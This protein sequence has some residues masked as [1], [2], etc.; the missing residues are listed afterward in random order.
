MRAHRNGNNL[1]NDKASASLIDLVNSLGFDINDLS[2]AIALQETSGHQ[3]FIETLENSDDF[4]IHTVIDPKTIASLLDFS[5]LHQLLILNSNIRLMQGAW[6]GV[7][8][9]SNTLRLCAIFNTEARSTYEFQEFLSRL[10]KLKDDLVHL[11]F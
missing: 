6:L 1:I 4:F 2:N 9:R 3:W 5:K 10:V 7:D 11:Y 8:D